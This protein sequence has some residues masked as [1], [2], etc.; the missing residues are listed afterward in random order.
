MPSFPPYAATLHRFTPS[1]L[2]TDATLLQFKGGCDG[3]GVSGQLG[4]VTQ[5]VNLLA[6][7]VVVWQRATG[8]LLIADGHQRRERALALKHDDTGAPITLNGFLLDEQQGWTAPLVKMFC[9]LKNIAE[10][11]DSTKPIDVARL[12]RN[13]ATLQDY[14]GIIAPTRSCY[15]QG[16]GLAKLSD[17]AFDL[18]LHEVKGFRTEW[19]VAVG[20]GVADPTRHM[21]ALNLIRRFNP[22]SERD[23]TLLVDEAS[24]KNT[25][26][27]VGQGA[28][29]GDEEETCVHLI[30]GRVLIMSHIFSTLSQ[31][32]SNLLALSRLH[33]RFDALAALIDTQKAAPLIT[34]EQERIAKLNL[35]L[36]HLVLTEKPL[37][38]ALSQTAEAFIRDTQGDIYSR[39]AAK[40][41]NIAAERFVH[42]L[43]NRPEIQQMVPQREAA[44]PDEIAL[45]QAAR[46]TPTLR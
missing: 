3:A 8:D 29:F 9:A 24:K 5:W 2:K 41:L 22:A 28:L 4:N 21:S 30:E 18:F 44:L 39:S 13:G 11:G 25:R 43:S 17:A 7:T 27:M 40:A 36:H 38:T 6:N 42:F 34:A 31:D 35:A 12:I 23:L 33:K 1:T 26:V 15:T 32:R 16:M 45:L 37:N 46:R 10:G 19:G 14:A 20:N